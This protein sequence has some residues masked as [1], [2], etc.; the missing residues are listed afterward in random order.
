MNEDNST[1]AGNKPQEKTWNGK[2]PEV[3]AEEANKPVF[4]EPIILQA[5]KLF[6][7]NGVL[8]SPE[9]GDRLQAILDDAG[10]NEAMQAAIQERLDVVVAKY[11]ER[12]CGSEPDHATELVGFKITHIV[13]HPIDGEIRFMRPIEADQPTEVEGKP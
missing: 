1:N 2:P 12:Y 8:Q 7:I 9:E 4:F 5:K 3:F 6:F 10:K 13:Q 11:H